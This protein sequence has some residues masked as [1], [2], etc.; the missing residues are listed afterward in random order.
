[1]VSVRPHFVHLLIPKIFLSEITTIRTR[2]NAHFGQMGRSNEAQK[3]TKSCDT[4][5]VPLWV[6]QDK[7]RF[8]IVFV[9]AEYL[10]GQ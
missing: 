6:K 8:Q 7:M 2:I 5:S 3:T 9:S 10:M 4:V 1:M